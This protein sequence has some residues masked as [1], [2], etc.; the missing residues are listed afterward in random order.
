MRMIVGTVIGLLAMQAPAVAQGVC[1][2]LWYERNAI[3]KDAGYCFRTAAAIR[4]FGNAGC[5]Y[6]DQRDVPLSQN[7]RARIAD[8]VRMERMNG[9]AR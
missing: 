8:I 1:A 3:Y 5:R 6:V 4:E 7:Q 2:D 9:C